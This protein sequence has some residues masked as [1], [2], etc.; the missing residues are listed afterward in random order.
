MLWVLL[1]RSCTCARYRKVRHLRHKLAIESSASLTRSNRSR[2]LFNF[3]AIIVDSLFRSTFGSHDV[4]LILLG[5]PQKNDGV[6]TRQASKPWRWLSLLRTR[7]KI[8]SLISR[9][10]C[11]QECISHQLLGVR[12]QD[13]AWPCR[14]NHYAD[15]LVPF[16]PPDPTVRQMLF[17]W[18]KR[19]WPHCCVDTRMRLC[20]SIFLTSEF[21]ACSLPYVILLGSWVAPY[22]NLSLVGWLSSSLG[23]QQNISV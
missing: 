13:A 4:S 16:L 14:I 11:L 5:Y 21:A 6:A 2:S 1:I 17:S 3:G 22:L 20:C 18:N 8:F 15:L 12:L 7:S 10:R 19:I 23:N 9:R